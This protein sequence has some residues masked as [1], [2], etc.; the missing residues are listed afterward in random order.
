[1]NTALVSVEP[2]VGPKLEL[3]SFFEMMAYMARQEITMHAGSEFSVGTVQPLSV[4]NYLTGYWMGI[5][6]LAG[7]GFQVTSKV[8]Y[9]ARSIR[10]LLAKRFGKKF[11]ELEESLV[12]DFISEYCNLGAGGTKRVLEEQGIEVG[13]SLPLI[14]R[15]FDDLFHVHSDTM[16]WSRGFDLTCGKCLIRNVVLLEKAHNHTPLDRFHWETPN[17]DED[18]DDMEFL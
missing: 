5:I 3:N 2:D 12:T 4:P 8:F 13:M 18:E 15:S 14:T 16:S 7:E 10:S 9:N 1:M 6:L 17:E 11:D